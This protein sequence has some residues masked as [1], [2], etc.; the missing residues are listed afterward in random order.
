MTP[1]CAFF[2][3]IPNEPKITTISAL[4]I[5]CIIGAVIAIPFILVMHAIGEYMYKGIKKFV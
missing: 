3:A 4:L 2:P 1:I 5:Y